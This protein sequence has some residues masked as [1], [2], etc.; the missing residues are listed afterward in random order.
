MSFLPVDAADVLRRELPN[1][2]LVEAMRPLEKLR[3]IKTAAEL[4]IL[5]EASERVVA[6]M[7]DAVNHTRPG[8]SK[9]EIIEHLRQA[10]L[11]RDMIFEYA[12][13]TMGNEPQ[14]GAVRATSRA[15][16]ISSHWISGGNYR[17]YIGDLC[18]MAVHGAPDGELVDLLGGNR[19]D[20]A[21]G[22]RSD[23]RRSHRRRYLRCRE[24]SACAVSSRQAHALRRPWHGHR[25][26]RSAAPDGER[27][28]SLLPPT[29]P[30]RRSRPAWSSR[31]KP[32]CLTT[33]RGF[34]KL[35][36]TIAVTP[37]G[38][39]PSAMARAA[40]T[41][42]RNDCEI[43]FPRTGSRPRSPA[44]TFL[45]KRRCG[46][47]GPASCGGSTS[48][49]GF[50]NPSIRRR[51]PIT[52]ASYDCQF[53]G[54]Q[55][56]T[57]D[58]SHLLAQDLTLHHRQT[59]VE[60]ERGLDNRLNDGRVDARGRLWIGTMDNQLHRPNGS[61][62]RVT[63]DGQ[64]TRL[65]DDVIVTNGIAFSPDNRTF[66]FT[67]TRRYCTWAFDFDLDD[68]LISNRRLF[69][70]YSASEKDLTARALTSMA[71]CGRRSSRAV[72]WCV[73]GLTGRSTR[74]FRCLSPIRPVF[75]SEEAISKRC[76]VTTARKFLD[77]Q[78]LDV[79]PQAGASPGH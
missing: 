4:E 69:A 37:D 21:G 58:G 24:R 28:H 29:T 52:Y 6:S 72:G 74:S 25:Q 3:S 73:I 62:Y 46:A 39:R 30:M 1:C 78:Q 75:A 41:G 8:H 38:Y 26:P 70:D 23:P 66:Y 42:F 16:A 71:G 48:T 33:R 43:R 36:D 13:V 50:I 77:R 31:L 55:A 10:E 14:P 49:A 5:R 64:V 7:M 79:E 56:L 35:E 47:T 18:R 2:Q 53:L 40:G 12:L 45:A 27:T 76:I 11:S 65:F 34:I 19:P 51:A 67:D 17:G 44:R 60:V 63:G 22:P 57:A 59:V 54:S 68:G 32:R 20:P 61:L 9:R 15:A